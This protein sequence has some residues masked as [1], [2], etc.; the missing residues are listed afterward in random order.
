MRDHRRMNQNEDCH[1]DKKENKRQR[2]GNWRKSKKWPE[3]NRPNSWHLYKLVNDTRSK[4]MVNRIAFAHNSNK[5]NIDGF[6][7]EGD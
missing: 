4:E 7:T 1:E 6:S 3:D 2:T 5:D